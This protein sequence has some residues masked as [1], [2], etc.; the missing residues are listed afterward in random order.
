VGRSLS[1]LIPS[2]RAWE[3]IHFEPVTDTPYVE[4]EYL[5]GPALKKTIGEFGEIEVLPQ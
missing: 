3:N 4:E 5:P 2:R 1:V